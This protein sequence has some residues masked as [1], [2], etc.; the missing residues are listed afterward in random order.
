[1]GSK[2]LKK[3]TKVLAKF[4]LGHQYGKS[5]GLPDPSGD[6][7]YGKNKALSPA[8]RADKLAKTQMDFQ[9]EQA[10]KVSADAVEQARASANALQ[11]SQDRQNIQAAIDANKPVDTTEVDV[12]VGGGGDAAAKRKKFSSQSASAGSG[13]PA[14]RI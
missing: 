3:V 1:M 8:E 4:D 5:L 6:L 2:S 7:I 10:D 11:L 9:Q 14:I 13:G 12:A